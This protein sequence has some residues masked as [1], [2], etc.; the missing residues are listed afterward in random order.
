MT[1]SFE[2]LP[3]TLDCPKCGLELTHQHQVEIFC[4]QE[5]GQ[6]SSRLIDLHTGKITDGTGNNPSARRQGIRVYMRC[7]SGC[8]FSLNIYQHKGFT[9]LDYD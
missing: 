7:E 6:Q 4:R 1:N 5:D 9:C 8:D 3:E 2:T